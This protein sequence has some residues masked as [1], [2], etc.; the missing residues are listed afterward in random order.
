MGIIAKFKLIKLGY[1][2]RERVVKA[3]IK[4]YYSQ[5]KDAQIAQ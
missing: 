4:I 3:Y 1:E 5:K 2:I